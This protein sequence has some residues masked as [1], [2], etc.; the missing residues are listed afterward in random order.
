[1]FVEI[2]AGLGVFLFLIVGIGGML[3]VIKMMIEETPLIF[4]ASLL[5]SIGIIVSILI[6]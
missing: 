3:S 6:K 1:M 2:L 5:I 4:I